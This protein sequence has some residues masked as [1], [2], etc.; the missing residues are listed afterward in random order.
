MSD[1]SPSYATLSDN[2][3]KARY[4][5]SYVRSICSQAGV[6]MTETSPDEDVL[7]VDCQVH[8]DIGDVRMQVKCTSGWKIDGVSL[9]FPLEER[10][11]KIWA[12]CQ[13]PVYLVVV[14]VPS[15]LNHW[16]RH[17]ADGT[18]HKSAAFWVRIPKSPGVSIEVPKCQR[19]EQKTL[20]TWYSDLVAMYTPGG[21]H[22]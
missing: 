9:T 3:R 15:Q 6:G 12:R 13:V 10:W 4:G 5:V 16:M 18:F 14:I 19:L 1:A 11:V 8:F 2:G 17:D 20:S 22:E 7:A 21:D